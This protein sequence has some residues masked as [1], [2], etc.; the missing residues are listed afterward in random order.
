MR[1][2]SKNISALRETAFTYKKYL[3]KLREKTIYSESMNAW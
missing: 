3:K 2:S 1:N